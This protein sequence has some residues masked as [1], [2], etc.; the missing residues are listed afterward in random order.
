MI[1][2]EYEVTNIEVVQIIC[3]H[4]SK[5]LDDGLDRRSLI[6]FVT[7]RPG[8]DFR[9]AVDCSRIRREVGW[10]PR[11]GFADGLAATIDWYLENRAWWEP[12]LVG[13]HGWVR[14][15]LAVAR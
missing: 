1:G 2:G 11:I 5:R 14:R 4:V 3:E 12:L 6:E 13:E 10:E 15:G 8:H 9:Y 7:D